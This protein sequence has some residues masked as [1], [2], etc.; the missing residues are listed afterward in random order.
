MKSIAPLTKGSM[1][2]I[3]VLTPLA[4]LVLLCCAPTNAQAQLQLEDGDLSVT[5]GGR[6][7]ELLMPRAA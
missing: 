3:R 2:M 6:T 4:I 5:I 1:A 7:Q